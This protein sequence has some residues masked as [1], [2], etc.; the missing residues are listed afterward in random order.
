MQRAWRRKIAELLQLNSSPSSWPFRP[1]RTRS[2][3][4]SPPPF[5][6]ANWLW[7]WIA[8]QQFS[9]CNGPVLRVNFSDSGSSSAAAARCC[10]L[11]TLRSCYNGSPPVGDATYLTMELQRLK[12]WC[13]L[14]HEALRWSADAL[15]WAK[16]VAVTFDRH[17]KPCDADT[18]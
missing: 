16:H 15:K 12:P 10:A 9:C 17:A 14:T 13:D 1:S 5:R 18:A 6:G 3:S 4:V 7:W 11:M 8:R 2:C